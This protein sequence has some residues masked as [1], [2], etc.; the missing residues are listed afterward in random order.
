MATEDAYRIINQNTVR[1]AMLESPTAI[2]NADQ[3]APAL[4]GTP[5]RLIP[6]ANL[7]PGG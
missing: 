6:R 3:I 1:I 2:E 4:E 5:L 7:H